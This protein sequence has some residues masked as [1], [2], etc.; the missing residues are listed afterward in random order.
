MD[1]EWSVSNPNKGARTI[2]EIAKKSKLS[3]KNTNRFN[4][5]HVPI[6]SFIP[7]ERVV[8]DSLH[9]FLCISDTINNLLIRDL[10]IQDA[11]N[12]TADS[13]NLKIYETFL[14]EDCKIRFKWNMD[15]NSKKIEISRFNWP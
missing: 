13:T 1:K 12:K 3:K 15:K 6:F 5:S 9:M 8:I 2:D 11:L 4:C 14:N 7:I 10:R